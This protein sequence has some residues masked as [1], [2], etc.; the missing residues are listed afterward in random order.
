VSN[1]IEIRSDY[2][3]KCDQQNQWHSTFREAWGGG[4]TGVKQHWGEAGGR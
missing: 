4:I 3:F 2:Q 1:L